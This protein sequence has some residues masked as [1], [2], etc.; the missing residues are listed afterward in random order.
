MWCISYSFTKCSAFG[1][2]ATDLQPTVNFLKSLQLS[3][4]EV[5]QKVSKNPVIFHYHLSVLRNN[6]KKLQDAVRHAP[7]PPRDFPHE[8]PPSLSVG[9]R[10]FRTPSQEFFPLFPYRSVGGFAPFQ[11]VL[12]RISALFVLFPSLPLHRFFFYYYL[13][14]ERF[15]SSLSVGLCRLSNA[16]R[17]MVVHP[18]DLLHLPFPPLLAPRPCSYRI[19]AS[20]HAP[21]PNPPP[22]P[23]SPLSRPLLSVLT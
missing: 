16:P 12:C 1:I 6:V 3:D 4:E 5:A 22:H 20:R 18:P 21:W 11:D 19:F 15:V 10:H 9:L 17:K 14:I 13:L 23:A 7:L 2:A 8:L